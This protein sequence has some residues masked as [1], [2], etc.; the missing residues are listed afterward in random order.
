MEHFVRVGVRVRTLARSTPWWLAAAVCALSLAPAVA[1]QQV[2]GADGWSPAAGAAGDNTYQGFIDQPS[3]GTNIP[4]GSLFHV[5]GWIVDTAAQGWAGIDD[6]QV[7]NGSTVLAHGSV[8]QSRPD[9]AAVTGNPFWAASGFDA[10]VPSASLPAG[11]AV[12][13]VAAHTPGKGSWSKQVNVTITGVGAV[14]T[15]PTTGSGIVLTIIAPAPGEVVVANNNGIVRGVAY[16]TRTRAELGTGVDRVQ[17]YLDGARGVADSQTLGTATLTDN[18]WSV[19]W[20]PTKYD[21]V[22]HHVL[23]VYAHSSVTGEERLVNLEIDIVH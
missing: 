7:L 9:V 22:K 1:A 3:P 14:I 5:S 12:L 23:W 17:V 4:L 15:S 6:V 10:V 18:T 21:H 2:P 8:A 19:A 20:E 13:T 16:D 11:P